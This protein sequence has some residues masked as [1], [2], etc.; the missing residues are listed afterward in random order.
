VRP[1]FL[2]LKSKPPVD[3]DMQDM[4]IR[5][6]KQEMENL[7]S[8]EVFERNEARKKYEGQKLTKTS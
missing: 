6:K 2:G 7:K 3:E 4:G 1:P 8:T 5:A